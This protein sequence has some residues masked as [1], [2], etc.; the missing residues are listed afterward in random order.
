M[1]AKRDDAA[2]AASGRPPRGCRGP[3][4]RVTTL[5]EDA[6]GRLRLDRVALADALHGRWLHRLINP[7]GQAPF[8]TLGRPWELRADPYRQFTRYFYWLADRDPGQ[9]LLGI[10]AAAL[11]AVR[12]EHARIGLD[13]RYWVDKTPFHELHADQ[14]A[15]AYPDAKFLHMVRD[16]RSTVAGLLQLGWESQAW[17]ASLKVKT[18]LSAA[19]RNSRR[20]GSDRY[21]VVRYEDLVNDPRGSMQRLANHLEIEFADTLLR[22]TERGGVPRTPNS[23]WVGPRPSEEIHSLSLDPWRGYLDDHSLAIVAARTGRRARSLGYPLAQGSTRTLLTL[24]T[25]R[26]VRLPRRIVRAYRGDQG[27]ETR[28]AAD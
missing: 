20:L 26:A 18:S 4:R 8:W 25:E 14:I 27:R 16:P 23:S 6:P 5:H 24:G 13:A 7:H 3:P 1:P 19:V 2:Q 15:T 22:P 28:P 11:A 17:V 9:D 10:V 21:L 12:L